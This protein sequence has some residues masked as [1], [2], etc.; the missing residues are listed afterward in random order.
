MLSA[1][2][3]KVALVKLAVYLWLTAS[4]TIEAVRVC[5][6][7]TD[8]TSWRE[9]PIQNLHEFDDSVIRAE[10]KV[11]NTNYFT[12]YD[13]IYSRYF[14]TKLIHYFADGKTNTVSYSYVVFISEEDV[15]ASDQSML[16]KDMR[17]YNY[18]NYLS[19]FAIRYVN[20]NATIRG[21]PVDHWQYCEHGNYRLDIYF[22]R[23]DF[24][25]LYNRDRQPPIRIIE[26][27]ATF[28]CVIFSQ[29]IK[30]TIKYM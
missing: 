28:Y 19:V 2:R 3:L 12:E 25:A 27:G 18:D 10:V 21:I 30:H 24:G 17:R 14:Y 29:I 26:K 6:P 8:I 22:P 23:A 9:M 20:D 5:D 13:D 1:M 16:Q 4:A 15:C 11:E 7:D